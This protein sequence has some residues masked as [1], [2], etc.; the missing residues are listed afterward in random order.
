MPLIET[1]DELVRSVLDATGCV[2]YG[3]G[4]THLEA[5]RMASKSAGKIMK[6]NHRKVAILKT[7]L[8]IGDADAVMIV[9]FN[10]T[11]PSGGTPFVLAKTWVR[12]YWMPLDQVSVVKAAEVV[13]PC[14]S[15]AR[16]PAGLLKTVLK[17][18]DKVSQ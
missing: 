5:R 11:K 10:S 15:P 3:S 16:L 6:H 1:G 17:E 14:T 8:S 13:Y 2:L 7:G 4:F 9:P 18:V 12:N